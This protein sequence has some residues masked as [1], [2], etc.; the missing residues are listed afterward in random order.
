MK[1]STRYPLDSPIKGVVSSLL[2]ERLFNGVCH[3]VVADLDANYEFKVPLCGFCEY[4][5]AGDLSMAFDNAH[6]L[7]K[8]YFDEHV[9]FI[10]AFRAK[11]GE[12]EAS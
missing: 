1:V 12:L 11:V 9:M 7:I 10:K 2:D 5:L 8:P 3:D 4:V 6:A